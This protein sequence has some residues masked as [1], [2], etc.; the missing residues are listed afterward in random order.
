MEGAFDD[1]WKDQ[2]FIVT[3]M[4]VKRC[5]RDIILMNPNLVIL[6]MKIQLGEKMSIMNLIKKLTINRNWKLI[7]DYDVIKCSKFNAEVP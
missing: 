6:G 1:K 2:K 4:C 5:F 7:L 3:I